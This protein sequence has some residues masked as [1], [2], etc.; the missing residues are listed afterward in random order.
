MVW[1]AGAVKVI[2]IKVL[3]IEVHATKV[4]VFFKLMLMLE[5]VS[6][7]T[8]GAIGL[9]PGYASQ[10]ASRHCPPGYTHDPRKSLVDSGVGI[11][12]RLRP[13]ACGSWC[14]CVWLRVR[15]MLMPHGVCVCH[16]EDQTD[17]SRNRPTDE[18]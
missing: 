11:L 17:S 6:K 2:T 4:S 1:P 12:V 7:L 9:R 13:C 16:T 5:N 8:E 3:P 10:G 18:F 14:V 15:V